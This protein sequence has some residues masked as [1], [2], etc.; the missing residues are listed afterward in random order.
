M[1][2]SSPIDEFGTQSLVEEN[3]FIDELGLSYW[4]GKIPEK[5]SWRSVAGG[6]NSHI[7][8]LGLSCCFGKF[9]Y[10]VDDL[11]LSRWW[12]KISPI[13]ELGLSC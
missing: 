9:R 8:E 2:E 5:I 11:G 3:S 4:W 13:D 1:G 7:G 10:T 12:G 6:G